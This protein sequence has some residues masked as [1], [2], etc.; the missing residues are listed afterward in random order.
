MI[1]DANIL[2]YASIEGF[3]Q[4]SKANE[5]LSRALSDGPEAIGI[6]WAT[7]T[8]FLRISTSRRIFAKPFDIGFAKQCLDDLFGH[9]LVYDVGPTS[10]HWKHYSRILVEMDLAGD[11]VMDAHLAAIALGHDASI[12]TSDKDFRR[13][14]DY[15]KII[16][17]LAK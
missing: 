13:F 3:A 6:P 10:D 1:L 16:D 17:P 14:S 5:W 8:A 11:I 12:A 15:V 9:P 4:Y 2:L 7:A